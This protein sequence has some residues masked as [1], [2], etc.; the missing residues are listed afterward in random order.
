MLNINQTALVLVDYQGKLATI[1]HG[2]ED[3]LEKMVSLVKG[4]QLLDI[5]IIWLEQYP[6]GLGPTTSEIKELLVGEEPIAKMDFSACQHKD[7]QAKINELGVNNYLVAGIEAH[8]CVYQTVKELLVA[9]HYVEYVVDAISSRTSEN[10]A[11]AMDKMNLLGAFPTSVE[12]ALFE[13]MGTAA[14]PSFKQVSR[15]IK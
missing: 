12:M 9:G 6:T 1:M 8:I 11:V 13:L 10:K 4:I 5:P 3:L 15:L 7:F 14:H 2:N